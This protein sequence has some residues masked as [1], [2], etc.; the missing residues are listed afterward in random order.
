M[1]ILISAPISSL[2]QAVMC[3]PS[4]QI[5]ASAKESFFCVVVSSAD[6]KVHQWDTQAEPL[7]NTGTTTV[8]PPVSVPL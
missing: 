5:A 6:H 7:Q 8:P 4:T 3:W 1:L 2:L